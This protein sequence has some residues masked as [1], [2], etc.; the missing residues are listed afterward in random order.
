MSRLDDIIELIQTTNEVYFITA[1]GRVRTAYILVD[2]IIELSLKVF[3]QEKVYE[4]R[5][6]CQ[7]DLESASLVTSRNHK[8]SL[9]RYFEEKLNIDELSNELG[10]GTTGVP[11]LQNHLVSFPLIRHWSANDPNARHTFDRVIDDVKPFFALPTTAPVGT[12]PNPATNL[13]DEAL[14]RHKTRNK[15]YHDQNLSGLDINDEK[16]LSA[17]CAMFDLVDHLFPTFSDEVKS[18]HTVRCQI[19]VLR[20]KQTASLGHRELSQPY[21]A[22]LQLLKKGH[23]YDF[24]RRSVEHSLVHTVSDRFFGSLREQFKNTIAKLQVRIN[25]I[26][27]MARP[28]QDHIDEKNDKEKLIQI[29]QK[30]LDQINALLGAP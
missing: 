24:E 17:L 26:D 5:V 21:E 18:K 23:K 2:D 29:L 10:R 28:K 22:A 16:C 1:P 14:I 30:Q 13:L 4:Q 19:G 9:R 12:P 27:T 6:N 8:D 11:I 7:I 20:L 3:L 25:K 15:F